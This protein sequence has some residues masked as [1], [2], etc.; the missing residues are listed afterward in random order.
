M[1]PFQGPLRR[2]LAVL[3]YN[4]RLVLLKLARAGASRARGWE[5]REPIWRPVMK[6]IATYFIPITGLIWMSVHLGCRTLSTSQYNPP[7][8][9][10][11]NGMLYYLPIGKITIKGEFKEVA[12]SPTPCPTCSPKASP[13]K[14]VGDDMDASPQAAAS[15]TATASPAR[16]GDSTDVSIGSAPQLTIT[17]TSEVEADESK[18]AGVYYAKPHANYLY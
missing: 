7:S 10:A 15:P 13:A 4:T 9:S 5:S 11:I 2:S 16:G 12:P 17:L 6:K 8:G 3:L 14:A 1:K 18:S